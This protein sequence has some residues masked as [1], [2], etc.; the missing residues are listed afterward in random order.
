VWR[1]CDER[2]SQT[3]EWIGIG[4]VVVALIAGIIGFV[5]DVGNAVSDA[6]STVLDR[7]LQGG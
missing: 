5:P 2:G 7:V 3:V 6:I 4:A 1:R